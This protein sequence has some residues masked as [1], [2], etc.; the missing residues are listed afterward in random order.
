MSRKV[1]IEM[2]EAIKLIPTSV[3]FEELIARE[4]GE[5][6]LERVA[7]ALFFK[8]IGYPAEDLKNLWHTLGLMLPISEEASK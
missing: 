4:G 8:K 3:L 6:K 1:V 5:E 7:F 2:E